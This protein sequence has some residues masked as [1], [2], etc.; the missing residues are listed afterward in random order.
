MA[1]TNKTISELVETHKPKHFK[2]KYIFNDNK[3]LEELYEQNFDMSL[4]DTIQDD[5]LVNAALNATDIKSYQRDIFKGAKKPTI[6]ENG[7]ILSKQMVT[8]TDKKL[9]E[10]QLAKFRY[11]DRPYLSLKL[12]YE[13]FSI[14]EIFLL[15]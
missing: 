2:Y 13:R 6:L 14:I 8:K 7:I 1:S 15:V 9:S 10:V 12:I 5:D 4:L 11:Q 3:A